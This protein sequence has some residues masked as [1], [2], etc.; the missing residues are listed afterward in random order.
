M[1]ATIVVCLQCTRPSVVRTHSN[2]QIIKINSFFCYC[3]NHPINAI[4]KTIMW[5]SHITMTVTQSSCMKRKHERENSRQSRPQRITPA[6]HQCPGSSLHTRESP[7]SPRETWLSCTKGLCV[8]CHQM[9][10]VHQYHIC[11]Y[12]SRSLCDTPHIAMQNGIVAVK[13]FSLSYS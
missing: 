7:C 13:Q 3:I 4:W 12:G 10:V 1:V 6:V 9:H 8:H 11:P 5:L 2:L